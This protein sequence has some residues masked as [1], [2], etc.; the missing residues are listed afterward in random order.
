MQW[1]LFDCL[2]L[3]ETVSVLL[4]IAPFFQLTLHPLDL[5]SWTAGWWRPWRA[6]LCS[7]DKPRLGPK[8][9]A[10]LKETGGPPPAPPLGLLCTGWWHLHEKQE[11]NSSH[12]GSTLCSVLQRVSGSQQSGEPFTYGVD[13]DAELRG[14]EWHRQTVGVGVDG[15]WVLVDG[16]SQQRRRRVVAVQHRGQQRRGLPLCA[17]HCDRHTLSWWQR[18]CEASFDY[19][20]TNDFKYL[21]SALCRVLK[22]IHSDTLMCWLYVLF[23]LDKRGFSDCE[24]QVQII[25]SSVF[26]WR[27]S[28]YYYTKIRIIKPLGPSWLTRHQR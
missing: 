9:S 23:I 1:L 24:V 26:I 11:T 20:T 28:D 4:A 18:V 25:R 8:R 16:S 15:R 13:P 12:W 22:Y 5:C 17:A 10:D 19:F 7:G 27:W 6:H 3:S 14:A 21:H 2:N